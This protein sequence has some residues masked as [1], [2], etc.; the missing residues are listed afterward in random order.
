MNYVMV[1]STVN[2][3]DSARNISKILVEKKL[4]ACVN[5]VPNL[6]SIYKWEGNM[7]EDAEYLLLIKSVKDKLDMLKNVIKL[8]H[9]YDVPEIIAIDII[10]GNKD[11]LDWIDKSLL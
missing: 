1:I 9:P 10:D 3:I 8:A 4:A 5:I 11:Y 6:T 2:N 7:C